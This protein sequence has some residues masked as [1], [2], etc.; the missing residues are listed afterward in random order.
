M[1]TC[2]TLHRSGTHGI[3]ARLTRHVLHPSMLYNLDA[4]TL[5][6]W[7]CSCEVAVGEQSAGVVATDKLEF[8]PVAHDVRV[9]LWKRQPR[10]RLL[11]PR[12]GKLALCSLVCLLVRFRCATMSVLG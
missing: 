10:F 8:F 11:G 3:Q 6:V 5:V 2:G 4:E 12:D 9:L 1:A 7:I